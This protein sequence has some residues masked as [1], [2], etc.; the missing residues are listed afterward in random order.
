MWS[1]GE[2]F[3]LLW[4][5]LFLWTG[6]DNLYKLNSIS[7]IVCYCCVVFKKYLMF[8]IRYILCYYIVHG[9]RVR[10]SIIQHIFINRSSHRWRHQWMNSEEEV[11]P[12]I[13]G[14]IG[15]LWFDKKCWVTTLTAHT[16]RHTLTF[17]HNKTRT[18]IQCTQIHRYWLLWYKP[19]YSHTNI[20]NV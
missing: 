1:V 11:Q 17:I 6:S 10:L 16:H 13:R 20:T 7:S 9:R 14:L 2:S 8:L 15:L 12:L 18:R 3:I 5:H 19:A 4:P